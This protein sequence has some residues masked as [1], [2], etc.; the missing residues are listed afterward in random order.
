VTDVVP[1]FDVTVLPA[2]RRIALRLVCGMTGV[3]A[4]NVFHGH[5]DAYRL[6]LQRAG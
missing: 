5:V 6:A 2:W 1:A 4:A 3:P